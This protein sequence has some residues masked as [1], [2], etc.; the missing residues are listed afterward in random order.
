MIESETATKISFVKKSNFNE[1]RKNISETQL[2]EKFGGVI[3]NFIK[4]WYF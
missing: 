3:P 1:L 4:Y 2:E